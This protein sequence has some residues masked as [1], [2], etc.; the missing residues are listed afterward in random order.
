MGRCFKKCNNWDLITVNKCRKQ[1]ILFRKESFRL[2]ICY[3]RHNENTILILVK[4]LV[5]ASSLTSNCHSLSVML[6]SYM[7]VC[8]CLIGGLLLNNIRTLWL[9]VHSF[10]IATWNHLV[11][12]SS[13]IFLNMQSNF[14]IGFNCSNCFDFIS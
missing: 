12:L 2:T 11:W 8:F 13:F 1:W 9:S 7:F 6:Y 3:S 14:F 4:N 5:L 10:I